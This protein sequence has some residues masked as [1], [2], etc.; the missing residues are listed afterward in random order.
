MNLIC[1]FT[2]KPIA[3]LHTVYIDGE[4]TLFGCKLDAVGDLYY[5]LLSISRYFVPPL[6]RKNRYSSGLIFLNS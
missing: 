3:I 1:Q 4:L 2:T 5:F 6:K